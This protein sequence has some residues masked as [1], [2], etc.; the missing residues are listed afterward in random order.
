[1]NR[2][3]LRKEAKK[4]ASPRPPPLKFGLPASKQ[5]DLNKEC[6]FFLELHLRNKTNE[7]ISLNEMTEEELKEILKVN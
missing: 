1:M 7:D 3:A 2:K 6:D 5:L 4:W